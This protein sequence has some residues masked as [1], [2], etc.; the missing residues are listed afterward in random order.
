MKTNV[1][2]VQKFL[3]WVKVFIRDKGGVLI[4]GFFIGLGI[5]YSFYK[6]EKR[7]KEYVE[8]DNAQLQ[9]VITQCE[10]GRRADKEDFLK[11]MKDLW[12]FSEQLK[13]GF[14]DVEKESR[15]IAEKKESI[16]ATKS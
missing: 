4:T 16:L 8:N 1:D 5:G 9:L 12:Y 7:I 13:S 3:D 10:K 6:S 2:D 15:E 11:N 14:K